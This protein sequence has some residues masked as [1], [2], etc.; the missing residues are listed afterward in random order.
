MLVIAITGILAY[1]LAATTGIFSLCRI[2]KQSDDVF[3]C[4]TPQ[5]NL[6]AKAA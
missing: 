2:A 6:E 3:A 5:S 1:V 4:R